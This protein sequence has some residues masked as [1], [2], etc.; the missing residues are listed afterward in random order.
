MTII[1]TNNIGIIKRNFFIWCNILV[2]LFKEHYKG[3]ESDKRTFK[4]DNNAELIWICD[5]RLS[6]K[7]R[8]CEGE[9]RGCFW[10]QGIQIFTEAK[11][12]KEK[13]GE[14][15]E[16][17]K[18][19]EEFTLKSVTKEAIRWRIEGKSLFDRQLQQA[20]ALSP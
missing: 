6:Q 17:I 7:R 9:I 15:I 20:R 16:G 2:Y 11:E 12:F 4:K 8:I 3:I 18:K 10:H 5:H 19:P 1:K 14:K 13:T